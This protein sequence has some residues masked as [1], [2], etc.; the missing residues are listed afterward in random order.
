M[1]SAIVTG[2]LTAALGDASVVDEARPCARVKLIISGG[3]LS[4]DVRVPS[5]REHVGAIVAA[6]VHFH[7]S[8]LEV[9]EVKRLAGSRFVSVTAGT[10]PC[11]AL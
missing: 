6:P 10:A 9:H 5:V 1:A 8:E 11:E 7:P 2:Q 3:A 4:P